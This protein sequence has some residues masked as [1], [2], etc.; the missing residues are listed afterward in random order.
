VV[1]STA[2]NRRRLYQEEEKRIVEFQRTGA[3]NFED[4]LRSCGISLTLNFDIDNWSPEEL[5]RCQNLMSRTNQLNLS[6]TKLSEQEFTELL[7]DNDIIKCFFE[8]KD[9]FGS[10]GIVGFLTV[11][12]ND[13]DYTITNLVISCRV[14]KKGIEHKLIHA[15]FEKYSLTQL[16]ARFIKT[17]KNTPILEEMS[18]MGW[19]QISSEFLLVKKEDLKP[20]EEIIN[21]NYGK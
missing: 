3:T 20:D 7:E 13:K 14:A 17:S 2:K 12:H 8:V 16:K 6:G 19:K 9:R 10:Y 5:E 15:L 4:F 11:N 21:L 1:D 18:S